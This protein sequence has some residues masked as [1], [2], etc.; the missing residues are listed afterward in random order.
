MTTTSISLT[1]VGENHG[2]TLFKDANDLFYF[3]EKGGGL[4]NS[5]NGSPRGFKEIQIFEKIVQCTTLMDIFHIYLREEKKWLSY[6]PLNF[7]EE[8]FDFYEGEKGIISLNDDFIQLSANGG[9]RGK[10]YPIYLFKQKRWVPLEHP[11]LDGPDMGYFEKCEKVESFRNEQALFLVPGGYEQTKVYLIERHTL[12]TIV[13]PDEHKKENSR[14]ERTLF[15]HISDLYAVCMFKG[16]PD[17]DIFIYDFDKKTYMKP[18]SD[19]VKIISAQCTKTHLALLEK[20][21]ASPLNP[22]WKVYDTFS[23]KPVNVSFEVIVK[24]DLFENVS[25]KDG[26]LLVSRNISEHAT[27]PIE[28]MPS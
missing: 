28:K 25:I 17:P 7:H 5:E 22:R 8:S 20:E 26:V 24:T 23:W 27:K 6:T 14:N 12:V 4:I 9:P 13:V 19:K 15:N 16:Y 11:I 10:Y 1:P 3:S 2:I 21:N 18:Y